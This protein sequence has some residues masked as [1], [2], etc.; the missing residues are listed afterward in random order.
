MTFLLIINFEVFD[1]I[2]GVEFKCLLTL[3]IYLDFYLFRQIFSGL[4]LKRAHIV[5]K[6]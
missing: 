6:Y 3:Q 4:T 1:V 5:V 2:V